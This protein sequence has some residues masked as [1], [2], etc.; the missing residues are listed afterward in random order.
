[1][2]EYEDIKENHDFVLRQLQENGI[3]VINNFFSAHDCQNSISE[4]EKGLLKYE[5]LC[6]NNSKEGLSGDQRLFKFE[7]YSKEALKFKN[8]EFINAIAKS[9]LKYKC[10]NEFVL[11]G[12][13]SHVVGKSINSGGDWHRDSDKKQFKSILYLDDVTIFN[14]PFSFV[15]NSKKFDLPRRKA[16]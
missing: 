13:V 14:G 12:K 8:N 10:L 7:N 9:Y 4:I 2:F 11:A 16:E 1:M 15:L 3:I 6:Q 5:N